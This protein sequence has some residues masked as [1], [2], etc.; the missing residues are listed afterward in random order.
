MMMMK[1]ENT[2]TNSLQNE[3]HSN[4]ETEND[5]NESLESKINSTENINYLPNKRS[6]I[7]EET[8]SLIEYHIKESNPWKVAVLINEQSW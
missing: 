1:H 3:T 7:S 8:T 4:N 5:S 2:K 6:L